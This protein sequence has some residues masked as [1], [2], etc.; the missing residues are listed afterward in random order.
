MGG[1]RQ[2]PLW[3]LAGAMTATTLAL[4]C[5]SPALAEE[6]RRLVLAQLAGTPVRF[7]IPPQPL[8]SALTQFGERA[9]VSVL[10]PAERVAGIAS[11][12]VIGEW[13]PQAALD[14]LLAGTGLI[15]RMADAGT[16]TV[17]AIAAGEG[18]LV[19]GPITVEAAGATAPP[20]ALL[21]TLPAPY[22][23]GQVA[24]GGQLGLLGNRDFMEVPFSTKSYTAEFM[25]D[26]QPRSLSGV[27]EAD[28][29]VRSFSPDGG[30]DDYL[31]IRGFGVLQ[32]LAVNGL[33]GIAP[34]S[35]V[36]V[37]PFERVELL[38]GPSAFLFG[39]SPGSEVGGSVNL[40]PKR[41]GQEPVTEVTTR[42]ASD[43]IFGGHLDVGR[44]YGKDNRFGT[45][46]NA[47]YRDGETT[48][49]DTK[50]KLGGIWLGN[51]FAGER[52][53]VSLDL[54][55]Q[56]RDITS[57]QPGF[58]VLPGFAVPDAP[59]G[60]TDIVQ[61]WTYLDRSDL[62]G[63]VR[64]EYDVLPALTGFV[65][66]GGR[67]T[68]YDS[69]FDNLTITNGEGDSA[70]T[71]SF[72]TEYTN[73]WTGEAGFRS[74]FATGPIQHRLAASALTFSEENGFRFLPVGGTVLSNIYDPVRAPRPSF[75]GLS[76]S[77]L[78]RA[79]TQ[80]LSGVA[81]SD[82]LGLLDDRISLIVGGRL[83]RIEQT[84][85]DTETGSRT[86]RYDES[87]LTPAI[88][89]VIRPWEQI[90]LYGNYVE[91]LA[92][93]PTAPPDAAN[94]G[95]SFPP[96][97]TKQLEFGAKLDL[98]SFGATLG[99]FEITQPNA[100][101]DVA[102]RVFSVDGEQRNRGVE[103]E[104]FGEP[105]DGVR[106]LGGVALFDA[107]LTQTQGGAND[108]N[109]AP[110]I[111]HWQANLV[112]EW[113]IPWLPGLTAGGRLIYSGSTYLDVEN[114]QSIPSW[115]QADVTARYQFDLRGTPVT[116][117]GSVEN[118]FDSDYWRTGPFSSLGRGLPR[119][120]LAS[121]S[122]SF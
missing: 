76:K 67:R 72:F 102:T 55:Y 75:G 117:R 79:S 121:T 66:L 39:M 68:L 13:T 104:L 89:V 4:W 1:S 98:G 80:W 63:V 46:L 29:S 62:L 21:G 59:N 99:L 105:L 37:E 84:N 113:D 108:G 28:P 6:P 83:Q 73:T 8:A 92:P 5:L 52:L 16:V 81:V 103:L 23:G 87:D 58:S 60:R 93:G 44:R 10:V 115:I 71:F 35:V 57:P 7:A 65:A 25:Q 20:T 15:A 82:T 112:G 34:Q 24:R 3:R 43:S 122:V 78:P 19:L 50:D 111:P 110:G 56:Q 41:A 100:I 12:G 120:F 97:K 33:Y 96:I 64:A 26:K 74:E 11:P 118:V 17:E 116:I 95:E 2:G 53:R 32:N 27:L 85:Y 48:I 90:S 77:N 106:L 107:E 94:A 109:D 61:E 69:V 47:F 14:R 70:S 54:A 31:A 30:L 88:G 51:D 36:A 38:K 42:Y 114:Q 91:G 119:T 40:V 49:D 45:R 101:T 22:A 9:G 86:N 18:A